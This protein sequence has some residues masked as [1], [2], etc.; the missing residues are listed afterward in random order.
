MTATFPASRPMTGLRPAIGPR[1]RMMSSPGFRR[2]GQKRKQ[3]SELDRLHQVI[4]E[5]RVLRAASRVVVAIARDADDPGAFATRVGAKPGRHL[6]PIH[7]RQ[8]DVE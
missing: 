5:S 6:V 8:A 4:V 2:L 3:R 7:S 1:P